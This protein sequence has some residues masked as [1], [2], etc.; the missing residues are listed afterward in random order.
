MDWLYHRN[1]FF[2]I[3]FI[4]MHLC[5][6]KWEHVREIMC[7]RHARKFLQGFHR[8]CIFTAFDLMVIRDSHIT[9]H[10][11]QTA[12]EKKLY[13]HSINRSTVD[14]PCLKVSN[15]LAKGSPVLL[16][17]ITFPW[18][19]AICWWFACRHGCC[20]SSQS[21]CA[22][23]YPTWKKKGVCDWLRYFPTRQINTD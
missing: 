1:C 2:Y 6:V 23:L 4:E 5:Q 9:H 14:I 20:L 16:R 22:K 7:V 10:G 21:D 17:S 8:S 13:Q 19:T 15:V 12:L 18:V 3:C 11:I